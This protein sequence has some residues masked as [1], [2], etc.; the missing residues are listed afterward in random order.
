M[1]SEVP[2]TAPRTRDGLSDRVSESARRL[3]M[4]HDASPIRMVPSGVTTP[5]TLAEVAALLRQASDTDEPVT[6]RSGGTS[7]NGQAVTRSRLIDVR[8]HFKDVRVLEA[9]A[10]VQAQP[11]ATV[12]AVNGRL[13]RFGRELGPDPASEI[14]A[15]IGGV[16]ANNSS[17]MTCGVKRNAYA[18]ID[19]A[20]LC[21]ADGLIIDTARH[22]ADEALKASAPRIHAGLLEIRA[23]LVQ[24]ELA[25]AEIRRQFS[26]KNTMGYAIN[27]FLDYERAIDI[28]L[29]LTVGS[30]G[31]LAFLGEVTLRTVA[32]RPRRH[33]S[34]LV[35]EDMASAVAAVRE[36][37]GTGARAIEL[38]DANSLRVA[39]Q[40]RTCPRSLSAMEISEHALLLVEMQERSETNLKEAVDALHDV[41]HR[42]GT[43]QS[44]D[45]GVE[46]EVRNAWWR[47]RKGLYAKVASAR[48]PGTSAILEDVA[49]PLP[50][51]AATFNELQMLL[52]AHQ[53]G[54]SVVFGHA[55][56]G[57]LHFMLAEELAS[58]RGSRRFEAF[59]DS[60][61]E[62]IVRQGGSLKAEHGT[63]RLMARFVRH[64]YGDQLF[65]VMRQ[66]KS[67][68][69][70]AAVLSPGVMF[71]SSQEATRI[72]F[73]SV[74]LVDSAIDGC[75][76]CGYC[77]AGC[78]SAGLTFTPRQRIAWHRERS[79]ADARGDRGAAAAL[80]AVFD[81]AVVD[82]C[83]VDGLCALACPVAIDTG[84]K[85]RDLRRVRTPRLLD[86]LWSLAARNWSVTLR[87]IVL[88]LRVAH[89]V[90]TVWMVRLTKGLRNVVG[91]E[92]VPLWAG[93]IPKPGRMRRSLGAATPDVVFLPS[94]TGHLFG[95][96]STSAF[97]SVCS[98]ARL[99]VMVPDGIGGMCCGT[100]WKSKGL[101]SGGAVMADHVIRELRESA[102]KLGVPVVMD[103]TSCTHGLRELVG[104]ELPTLRILDATEFV[105]ER[106]L[107]RLVAQNRLCALMLHPTCASRQ[108][109]ADAAL[110]EIAQFVAEQVDT[111]DDAACCGFAGDRGLLHPELTASATSREAA[112]VRSHPTEAHASSNRTCELGM[113]RAS[114]ANYRHILEYLDECSVGRQ[115]NG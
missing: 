79:L 62:L 80:D 34:A 81:Y 64:Q 92:S 55:M 68:F 89:G 16:V 54:D 2:P 38:L 74:P 33:T 77:E 37:A 115:G 96:G 100:P 42:L 91:E 53:Y 113:A 94:C 114:G 78:P 12:R 83:A 110:Q 41:L 108:L 18:T 106:V 14:A 73:E 107:D 44:S 48:Q 105:A 6:F 85:V 109:G 22:D 46:G 11:G 88:A 67:L 31:T 60:L 5:A 63:G 50:R 45:V 19:S 61:A 66:V 65:D 13:A 28:L 30:E 35:F 36:L 52:S 21:L 84:A 47:V 24:D 7:L 71:E 111:P 87:I 72:E 20:V 8:T 99:S 59:S 1:H 40:D 70:P 26:I 97:L 9:G 27:S 49:V 29:H 4:A 104:R 10:R 103:S 75:V 69:D 58:Q 101:V 43:H 90:P 15:T 82:T 95:G 32:T 23:A 56:D 25:V 98:K 112:E 3:V 86:G 102:E 51:L 57:N 93:D 17:G 76:D 39:Q